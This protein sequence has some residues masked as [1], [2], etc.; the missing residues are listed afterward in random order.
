[1]EDKEAPTRKKA[2]FKHMSGTFKHMPTTSVVRSS[3]SN[4]AGAVSIPGQGT[5][6]LHASRPKKPQNISNTATNSIKTL[7]MVHIKK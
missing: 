4:A 7:K 5:K 3:P 6:I 2:S 1:M